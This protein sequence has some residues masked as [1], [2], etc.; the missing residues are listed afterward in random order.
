MLHSFIQT[1]V[2]WYRYLDIEKEY[3]SPMT[4]THNVVPT[5]AS[6]A[7]P[8]RSFQYFIKSH[9]VT[10][11][12]EAI[13]TPRFNNSVPISL[14]SLL[15]LETA[16]RLSF[17]AWLPRLGPRTTAACVIWLHWELKRRSW[18]VV[19]K[20]FPLL[21]RNEWSRHIVSTSIDQYYFGILRPSRL[22]IPMA[23]ILG[24]VTR[25]RWYHDMVMRQ[26]AGYQQSGGFWL[27]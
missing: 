8:C 20:N 21:E 1:S 19:D 18:R 15:S 9:Y 5:M 4:P 13:L 17:K 3:S 11:D 23:V 25:E 27:L 2:L 22:Y 24:M 6:A 12:T 14:H 10:W 26:Y 16:P 7:L